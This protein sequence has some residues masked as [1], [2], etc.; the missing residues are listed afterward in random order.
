M[1]FFEFQK[2]FPT[3][4]AALNLSLLLSI[5]TVTIVRS[6]DAS[7]K[8]YTGATR[9]QKFSTAITVSQSS[10]FLQE[11]SLREHILTSECGYMQ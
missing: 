1:T 5:L 10:Q 2:R 9:E 4:T 11:L 8:A 6:V 7:T 3:E